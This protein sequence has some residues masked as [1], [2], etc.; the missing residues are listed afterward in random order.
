MFFSHSLKAAQAIAFITF[1]IISGNVNSAFIDNGLTTTDTLTTLEW[2]DLTETETFSYDQVDLELLT[3]GL[4]DG[5]RRATGAEISNM[6]ANFGLVTG[7]I[8][9]THLEF[10]SLFGQTSSQGNYAESFG[11]ADSSSYSMAYVYGLDFYTPGEN[12]LVYTGG[13]HHNKSINFDG[14]GSFLVVKTV[15]IPAA[16]WLFGSGIIGLIGVTRKK[17]SETA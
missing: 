16:I 9:A 12:Y 3:G 4:F 13:L 1:L 10:I 5:Y 8:N 7:P 6:F 17:L 14:F 2:L 11:Y 15:P